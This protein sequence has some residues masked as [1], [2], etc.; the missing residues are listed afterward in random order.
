[1]GNRLGCDGRFRYRSSQDLGGCSM[2]HEIEGPFTSLSCL[3]PFPFGHI[4]N[5]SY[6]EIQVQKYLKLR[7][8]IDCSRHDILGTGC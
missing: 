5:D 3:I 4:P 1:M 2:S 6:D 7:G 8:I